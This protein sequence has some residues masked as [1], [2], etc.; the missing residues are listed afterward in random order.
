MVAF[1]QEPSLID[2]V[3]FYILDGI[4]VVKCDGFDF[5]EICS[6]QWSTLLSASEETQ[7]SDLQK[8]IIGKTYAKLM[9]FF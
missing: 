3:I 8:N 5:F 1:T 9:I 7:A 6:W 4:A 2:R